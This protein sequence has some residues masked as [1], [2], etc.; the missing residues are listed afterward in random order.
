MNYPKWSEIPQEVRDAL[1]WSGGLHSIDDKEPVRVSCAEW[2]YTHGVLHLAGAV[3][4]TSQR[5][6]GVTVEPTL[7]HHADCYFGGSISF[8]L[9]PIRGGSAENSQPPELGNVVPGD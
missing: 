1:R 3:I 8:H 6:G 5:F 7:T 2:D 4:D 9:H